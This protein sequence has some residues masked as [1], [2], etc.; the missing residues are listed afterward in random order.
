MIRREELRDL[1]S[2]HPAFSRRFSNRI[3]SSLLSAGDSHENI[4]VSPSRL[5]AVIALLA[6]WAEPDVCRSMLEPLGCGDM[7]L[8]DVNALLSKQNLVSN[9][10]KGSYGAESQPEVE[11]SVSIWAEK[12][13]AIDPSS[14]DGVMEDYNVSVR[15][16]DFRDPATKGIIDRSI[17][18]ATHGLIDHLDAELPVETLA[19]IIDILYFKAA[20]WSPFE[21]YDTKDRMFYGVDGKTTVKMMNRTGSYDYAETSSCQMIS[22]P[23][24]CAYDSDVS[25]SMVVYLPRG[26]HTVEDVLEERRTNEFRTDFAPTDVALSLPRFSISSRVDM[27]DLL[28]SLGLGFIFGNR[29]LIP[30]CIKDL[31]V[32]QVI[33]QVRVNVKENG[34][35][36]AAMTYVCMLA[37]CCPDEEEPKPIVMKVNKPFLFEIIEDSSRTVLFTG[38]VNNIQE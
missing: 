29:N 18:E 21:E 25:F 36:A 4:A 8:G 27:K 31:M 1:I 38:V 16:V 28:G 26:R 3:L 9:I 15:N 7:C 30:K 24:M 34:T 17:S 12:S 6:N 11:Q 5:Q 23:Y 33:Q 32:S 19:A 13:L 10:E 20:W 2:R 35:E 14:V 37:G 22:L